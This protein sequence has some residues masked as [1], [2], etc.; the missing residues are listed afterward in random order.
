MNIGSI[1]TSFAQS[2]PIFIENEL[3]GDLVPEY[4]FVG[5]LELEQ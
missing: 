1:T 2:T 3:S 4:Q 5:V